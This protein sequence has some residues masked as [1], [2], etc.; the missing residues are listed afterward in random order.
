MDKAYS[1]IRF[2]TKGQIEGRSL[3][4]QTE[5]AERYATKHGLIL[6]DVSFHDLG[7][8]GFRGKNASEGALG[9]FLEAVRSNQ[10]ESGSWL[11]LESFDRMSRQ[12]VED[13]LP[14]LMDIVRLGINVVTLE[15]EAVFM[16]GDLDMTKLMI[17]LVKMERAHSESKR[18]SDLLSDVWRSKVKHASDRPTKGTLPQWL[19]Y[20]SDKTEILVIEP[21]AA[22][23]QAI[24]QMSV[25]GMGRASI[26]R[27][28][29]NLNVPPIG[30]SDKWHTSYITKL[31]NSRAVLGEYQP[32][33]TV[34]RTKREPTGETIANYYPP[35]VSES[36][37]LKAQASIQLRKVKGSGSLRKGVN[38]NLFSG[39]INCECGSSMNFVSKGS[40]SKG[41]YYLV[42][43]DARYGKGCQYVGHRYYSVQWVVLIA[44]QKLL[45]TFTHQPEDTDKELHLEGEKTAV[46]RTIDNLMDDLAE[47]GS[48]PA[49][50]RRLRSYEDKLK[51]I[52]QA[53]VTLKAHREVTS[54][55]VDLEGLTARI[56]EQGERMQLHQ[57]L[58][59]R[60][61]KVIVYKCKEGIDIE[62]KEGQ[63]IALKC[64]P[65]T[66]VWSD[67]LG[68]KFTVDRDTRWP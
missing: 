48:S 16:K 54:E 56:N 50:S 6:Q 37:W 67:G 33:T 8:S 45:H 51:E 7:V 22:L 9:Q 66:G 34:G 28:L 30:R 41:G 60:I 65:E 29:N 32:Q 19:Q 18:K 23:V 55:A 11:L 14:R 39:F 59:R 31:L 58:K 26:V 12:P 13:A 68:L 38:K 2:S 1:Y 5:R 21:K 43:S 61:A 63:T 57:F 15:D 62:L 49:I 42:C 27:E 4:R 52:E 20:N 17:S 36:L 47:Y 24:F 10:I 53:L 35:V 46:E 44:L 25:N 64:N 40:G 3:A